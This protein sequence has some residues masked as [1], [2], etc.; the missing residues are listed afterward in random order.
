[1]FVFDKMEEQDKKLETLKCCFSK[2]GGHKM[3]QIEIRALVTKPD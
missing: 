1:M 3:P 2:L